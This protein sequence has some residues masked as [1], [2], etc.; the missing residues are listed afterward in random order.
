MDKLGKSLLIVLLSLL[1]C[2]AI[3]ACNSALPSSS[4]KSS[5]SGEYS[6][7][8]EESDSSASDDSSAMPEDSSSGGIIKPDD[9]SSG[10]DESESFPV[11]A[12]YG[13]KDGD[14]VTVSGVVVGFVGNSFYL[15][16]ENNGVYVYSSSDTGVKASM[17]IVLTGTRTTFKNLV[18]LKSVT[19]V[20]ILSTSV[21]L[22]P[23]ALENLSF[24]EDYISMNIAVS[25]LTVDGNLGDMK[26]GNNFSVNISDGTYSM[27]LFMSKYL[28][29]TVR[30]AVY[31]KL[32]EITE[33]MTF[34][35]KNA[36]VSVF[37]TL[38]IAITDNTEI[39]TAVSGEVASI[40]TSDESLTVNVGTPFDEVVNR[41]SVI[42]LYESGI[43]SELKTTE[44]EITCDNYNADKKGEYVFTVNYKSLQT[45]VT[46]IVDELPAYKRLG[47]GEASPIDYASEKFGVSRGLP[48]KGNS[49]VL[50]IPVEFTDAK[51]DTN[52]R[53]NLQTAFFGTSEQ[54]G[55]ESLASYYYKS[56][57]GKLNI[58]G[59][60]TEVFNT[61]NSSVYYQSLYEDGEDFPEYRIMKAALGYFDDK[62]D[63]AQY[64]SD[65]DGLID[66]VYLVY[67][68]EVD[69]E[70]ADYWWAY[71]NEY[72]PDQSEY[73][74][75]KESDFYIFMGYDFFFETPASGKTLTLNC[76]TVI[77]E[78]GHM[79]G[80]DDYYDYDRDKGP[81][82]GIGGGDMMDYN[83][84]DHNAFTKLLL[85]WVDPYVANYDCT[86]TLSSFGKSG[87]CVMICKNDQNPFAEYFIIDYYTPDGLNAMAAGSSGLFSIAGIRIYH[88]DA[89]MKNALD[90]DSVWSIYKNNNSDT[91]NKLIALVEADG[92]NDIENDGYSENSDLFGLGK[93]VV[94][95]LKWNDGTSAGFTVTI[96]ASTSG[97]GRMLTIDFI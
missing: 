77:H 90:E 58:T 42:A 16:D 13:A 61:G 26:A 48:S 43:E 15:A 25:G 55:W 96:A 40:K 27:T 19:D 64:D 83:V 68:A 46:V 14:V 4:G 37:N 35:L 71:T 65:N 72:L 22:P 12:V 31:S 38:Q 28:S 63:Y 75:Q 1:T 9:S 54:T 81:A 8:Y 92:G 3:V 97:D 2:S 82:G 60:V 56:S 23:K 45:S 21:D 84:G 36:V 93:N 39:S 51:A 89:T 44:Y 86:I 57:Y 52:M 50:V 34:G 11:S 30:K 32:S 49:K 6:S 24:A 66:A 17:R 78:T 10:G 74:D 53:S 29:E 47:Y 41:I 62:I 59:T 76:E 7:G 18:E 85:G 20:R 5:E 91:K 33:G 95:G 73:Y 80:I 69:F 87:D 67:T 94:N 88:V 79:L 70:N